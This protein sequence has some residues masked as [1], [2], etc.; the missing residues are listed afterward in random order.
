MLRVVALLRFDFRKI[1]KTITWLHV[2]F[3]RR[4]ASVKAAA[5]KDGL[6]MST[7]SSM[8]VQEKGFAGK[9]A[10][11]HSGEVVSNPSRVLEHHVKN[12]I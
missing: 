7:F 2:Y 5:E 3:H 10:L 6:K 8:L 12:K 4:K 11:G 9:S 1:E